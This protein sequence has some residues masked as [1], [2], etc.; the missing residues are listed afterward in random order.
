MFHAKT[1]NVPANY[2]LQINDDRMIVIVMSVQV[3]LDMRFITV[4]KNN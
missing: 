1:E 3:I 4:Q 2:V